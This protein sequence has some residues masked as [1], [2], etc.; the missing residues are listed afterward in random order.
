MPLTI[1]SVAF[2]YVLL[3]L[4]GVV[5]DLITSDLIVN[6]DVRV[7][8]LLYVFR[9]L[10]AVKVF[11]WATLLGQSPTIIVFGL[12]VSAILYLSHK[13]WQIVTLWLTVIG[14]EAFT[15]LSK[16]IF[17][18]LRPANAVILEGSAS[19]PSGHATIAVAFY[20]FL[21]YLAC[22][23][24][25]KKR[26][27]LI[28]ILSGLLVMAA[29][30]F[31][32]LYLGVHYVS[33]VWAGYLVGLL[34]L[35]IGISIT[36]W[37]LF[38]EQGGKDIPERPKRAKTSVIS[39]VLVGLALAFY[40][41][42][43]L[44]Y[45]PLLTLK[46]SEIK[47]EIAG[48]PA[49][50]FSDFNLPRYT[51]TIVGKAQEPISFIVIAQ[52]DSAFLKYFQDAGWLVADAVGLHST[53]SLSKSVILNRNYPTAPMTPSFWNK[54]VHDFGFEKSTSANS[55]RARH[56]ARFWKT[57][58]RA[59]QGENIYVG[60]V[61]L[62]TGVKWLV[63]HQI[64][65][66]IDTEREGLFVDLQNSGLIKDYKKIQMVRPVLGENFSGDQFFTS[67]EAYV[68]YLKNPVVPPAFVGPRGNTAASA[69]AEKGFNT[70][71]IIIPGVISRSGQ[72]TLAEFQWLKDNGWK[73]VV[74][75]RPAHEYDEIASDQDIKGFSDLGFNYLSLPIV[76]GSVPTEAQVKQ[77]LAF[78]TDHNNQ[79]IEVHCR[80]G[81]G[82]TGVMIALYRYKVQGWPMDQAIAE[83]K[84]YNGGIN[85]D[86]AAWLNHFAVTN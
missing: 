13:K 21:V 73:S 81:I 64:S 10:L 18:R 41:I 45:Q 8:T 23:S 32:R 79:P 50:I 11:I 86:Q 66:D 33:D 75:L 6:A 62:D 65:P 80:A 83:S 85:S 39:I 20:G 82:R 84:L 55:A 2:L 42:Y 47:P 36:E 37:K 69:P 14:S 4:F 52:D 54:Q 5:E 63:T 46:T 35:I 59:A 61:S 67:G 17:H 56:H 74:D 27:R 71:A 3:L 48:D 15:F 78:V 16:I 28:T 25:K 1:L 49:N 43:G 53:A 57:D 34:W 29:I 76:D 72:P 24:L 22:R 60:T 12:I 58:L 7:N 38:N 40:I 70:F 44:S 9:S 19:F 77:F 26:Y 68:L 31:S 51:E 30:G